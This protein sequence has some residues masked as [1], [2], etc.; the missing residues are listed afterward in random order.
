MKSS[1]QQVGIINYHI[2]NF[3][4]QGNKKFLILREIPEDGVR[5]LLVN[6][7][8]LAGCDIAVFVHDRWPLT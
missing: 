6:K 7:E 2:S 3:F 1:V 8:S 4:M 5:K